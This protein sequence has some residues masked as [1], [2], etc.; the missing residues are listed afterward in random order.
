MEVYGKVGVGDQFTQMWALALDT[1]SSNMMIQHAAKII[2][3]TELRAKVTRELVPGPTLQVNNYLLH[4][5]AQIVSVLADHPEAAE[6][7]LQWH[8]K[9][10]DTRVIEHAAADD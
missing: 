9:R 8:Q 2:Q 1:S 7:V 10:R 6:A 5:A 3:A 4:D